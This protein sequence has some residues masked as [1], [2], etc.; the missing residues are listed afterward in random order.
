MSALN[1][2]IQNLE[3]FNH[4]DPDS[5]F[6]NGSTMKDFM[7]VWRLSDVDMQ[8]CAAKFQQT[9]E[10]KVKTD[11]MFYKQFS[12]IQPHHLDAIWCVLSEYLP[13]KNSYNPK[14]YAEIKLKLSKI[15]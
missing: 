5:I 6:C 8:C 12:I 15:I 14:V 3:K 2:L 11:P 1:I 9:F 7:D 13:A 10:Y 4:P